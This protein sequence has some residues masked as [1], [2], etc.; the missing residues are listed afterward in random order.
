MFC[1][2]NLLFESNLLTELT[3]CQHVFILIGFRCKHSMNV[4]RMLMSDQN[5]LQMSKK[6]K[7]SYKISKSRSISPVDRWSPIG[8]QHR[9]SLLNA[10]ICNRFIALICLHLF[11][12]IYQLIFVIGS[13]FSVST[14]INS[15]TMLKPKCCLY[16]SCMF[17][18]NCN[19]CSTIL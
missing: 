10:L 16:I 3:R 11:V 17:L 19:L 4:E 14:K 15:R 5:K 7:C 12:S 1:I 6:I 2:S 9:E 18:Y 13:E 8:L